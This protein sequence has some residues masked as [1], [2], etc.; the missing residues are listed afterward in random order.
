[1]PPQASYRMKFESVQQPD[2][3]TMEELF[4]G[5]KLWLRDN[6]RYFAD[7]EVGDKC[8][9]AGRGRPP[10]PIFKF[11]SSSEDWF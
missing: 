11:C 7:F 9:Q 1:M 10:G 4:Q 5:K 8:G 2:N 3:E 6:K